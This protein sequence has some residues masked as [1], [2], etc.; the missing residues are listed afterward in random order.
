MEQLQVQVRASAQHVTLGK[1][2]YAHTDTHTHIQCNVKKLKALS[3]QHVFKNCLKE[4]I[5]T[6]IH[7]N[8]RQRQ[9]HSNNN[10]NKQRASSALSLIKAYVKKRTAERGRAREAD[11]VRELLVRHSWLWHGVRKCLTVGRC[12]WVRVCLCVCVLLSCCLAA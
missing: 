6:K 2:H 4:K 12:V 5:T 7:N 3:V 1:L 8:N 11:W 10:R 9:A